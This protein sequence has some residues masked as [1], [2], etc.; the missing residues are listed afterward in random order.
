MKILHGRLE[1]VCAT[2]VL[3]WRVDDDVWSRVQGISIARCLL[4]LQTVTASFKTS[5]STI[6][7]YVIDITFLIK[8]FYGH[9]IY[10]YLEKHTP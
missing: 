3:V 4:H 7:L 6:S 1:A 2:H 10:F 5:N 9:F 8:C